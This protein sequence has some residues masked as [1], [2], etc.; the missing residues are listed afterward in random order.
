MSLEGVRL[1]KD[2]GCRSHGRTGIGKTTFVVALFCVFA[3]PLRVCLPYLC[4]CVCLTFACVFALPLR[5]WNGVERRLLKQLRTNQFRKTNVLSLS[6]SLPPSLP[7]SLSFSF[8]F[9]S[10]IRTWS[11]TAECAILEILIQAR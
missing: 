8:F 6:L 1:A 5:V 7:P 9:L 4:G 3:Q 2:P 11:A 10:L